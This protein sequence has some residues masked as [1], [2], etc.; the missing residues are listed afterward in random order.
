[1]KLAALEDEVKRPSIMEKEDRVKILMIRQ[2]DLAAEI[3]A[4]DQAFE[5]LNKQ[6]R[7]L[8]MKE[9]STFLKRRLDEMNHRWMNLRTKSIEIRSRLQTNAEQWTQLLKTLKEIIEWLLQKEEDLQQQQPIAGD[10]NSVYK[11]NEDHK[12]IKL[13]LEAKRVLVEHTLETG[14]MYLLDEKEDKRASSDSGEG[15]QSE[16]APIELTPE[17]EARHII[18]KIRHHVRLLNRK[19]AE[20]HQ[21][22]N[23]WQARID[24]NIQQFGMLEDALEHLSVD[25]TSAEKDRNKWKPVGEIVIQNLH[26]EIKRTKSFQQKFVPLQTQV[27]HVNNLANEFQNNHIVLSHINVNKL[28]DLNSRWRTL[29]VDIDNRLKELNNALKDFG[30]ESQHLLS[31]SV[32]H[33]WERAIAGNKVPYYINHTTETTHWDHPLFTELMSAISELN[34]VRFSAYRTAMKL[35]T[36][37]KKICLHLVGMNVAIDSF[38]SHGLRAQND[39]LMDIIEMMNC[40]VTMFEKIGPEHPDLINIPLCTDLV[41]NWL[42]NVY[43]TV[44]TGRIRV[45]S[46]KVGIILLCKAH[47]EDKFRF[48]FRLIADANGFVD[49]R[50]LALLLHDCIQ[51]PRQLGEIAAFGGS[52]IEPSVRSCFEKAH[53]RGRTDIQASDFLDWL[54]ME[55]QSMVWLPVLHRMAAAETAKHQSKCNICKTC[56]IIG[57]RYRCLKCFNFDMCQNCFFTGCKAKGHKLTHPMQEYCTTTTSGEDMRD[58]TKVMKNK[59]KSKRYFKKHPRLGYLPVQTVLEG[60]AIESPAPSPQHNATQDM[61]SRLEL[62]A[63]RLAEV[64]QRQLSSTPDSMIVTVYPIDSSPEHTPLPME[65]EHNLIAQYCH[66]LTGDGKSFTL[67]SPLQIMMSLDTDQRAELETMIKDLEE[68]NKQLQEE[69]DRLR[70]SEEEAARTGDSEPSSRDAEMIAEAKLLRQHKGR[71]EARMQILEDHN[72]QL[73]AQLQRL[74]QLLEQPQHASMT[75]S[76]R[77]TPFMTPSSSQTSLQ[78]SPRT[79][80]IYESP[81]H[82]NGHGDGRKSDDIRL[83]EMMREISDTF[84]MDPAPQPPPPPPAKST[85]IKGSNVGNLFHMA[86]QVGRA[87][88]TLVTVMTDEEGSGSDDYEDERN[89]RK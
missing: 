37:Q 51:I 60:D 53:A 21:K 31:A 81:V 84:P 49:Q 17:Q 35:R 63:T 34:G 19:W 4:H 80:L 40:C 3:E 72:R 29:T 54:K 75:S 56:P 1:M 15:S 68:E 61:H 13:S 87:V 70:Q 65:D 64:E 66:S 71:L 33:P 50:R 42:L 25:V 88:G 12:A 22:S 6:G 47:L 9:D 28:E 38:Q 14:R 73:E 89:I 26:D 24:R 82:L 32:D 48:I 45:L 10:L 11:Q 74:R 5:S 41:L 16:M 67:K 20:V 7:Q 69:Y 30:P 86:G 57:M 36:L 39:K 62:Y 83:Q 77:T 52:N 59:F 85:G 55:P 27:D 78:N 44:R 43:D 8:Q 58:F 2:K 79:K 76:Q 18:R 46:F 23:E